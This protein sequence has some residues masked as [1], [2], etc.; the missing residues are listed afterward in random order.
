VDIDGYYRPDPERVN[1]AM[2]PSDTLNEALS[3]FAGAN[4][5]PARSPAA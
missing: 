5:P 1:A 4:R 2:R 3:E